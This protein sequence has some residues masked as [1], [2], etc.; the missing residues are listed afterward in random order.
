MTQQFQSQVYTYVHQ[1]TLIFITALFIIV[2][3]WKHPNAH[4]HKN[5]Y[6][7][8]DVFILSTSSQRLPGKTVDQAQL[9]VL[10]V[11]LNGEIREEYL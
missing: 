3:N 6:I 9:T 2:S 7:N 4:Q 5:G 8:C 11:S 1:N 10:V